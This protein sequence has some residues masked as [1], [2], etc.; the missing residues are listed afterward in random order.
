MPAITTTLTNMAP[1]ALRILAY[2]TKGLKNEGELTKHEYKV[3]K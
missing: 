3:L 2:T 1:L